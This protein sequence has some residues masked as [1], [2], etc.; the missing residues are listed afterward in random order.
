MPP[1]TTSTAG[2]PQPTGLARCRAAAT[3]P[4]LHSAR[5]CPGKVGLLVQKPEHL[6]PPVPQPDTVPQEEQ[7]RLQRPPISGPI[8]RPEWWKNGAVTAENT[9]VCWVLPAVPKAA[10]DAT[11]PTTPS[12]LAP[13]LPAAFSA[14]LATVTTATLLPSALVPSSTGHPDGL[15]HPQQAGPWQGPLTCRQTTSN[16]G[17][18][19]QDQAGRGSPLGTQH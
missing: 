14:G 13:S 1:G 6:Q 9:Q 3:P 12:G 16:T 2:L 7:Q 5:V 4:A 10:P 15:E 17:R 8:S 11:Q 19:V 18:V